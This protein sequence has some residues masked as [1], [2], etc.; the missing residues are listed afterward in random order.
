MP[1]PRFLLPDRVSLLRKVHAIGHFVRPAHR[2]TGEIAPLGRAEIFLGEKLEV[3]ALAS[4][5]LSAQD[6]FGVQA[7]GATV[8]GLDLNRL[9]GRGGLALND[10]RIV[11]EAPN[12]GRDPHGF[13]F[14][15]VSHCLKIG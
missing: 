14:R 12:S 4:H 15:K 2:T 6:L 5:P 9:S 3:S 7:V 13:V 10:A 8:L 1:P 11:H